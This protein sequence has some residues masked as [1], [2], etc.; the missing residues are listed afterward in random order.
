MYKDNNWDNWVYL[1][2][3]F[4]LMVSLSHCN[5]PE[6][7]NYIVVNQEKYFFLVFRV[8]THLR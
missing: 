7:H 6:F 3:N 1:K 5:F 8:Q 4:K 2:I